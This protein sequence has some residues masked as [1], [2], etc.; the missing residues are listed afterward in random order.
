[1]INTR[2]LIAKPRSPPCK[3]NYTRL[4]LFIHLRYSD[5]SDLW[6][7][8]FHGEKLEV[9]WFNAV[10]LFF[11]TSE[12]ASLDEGEDTFL[13]HL[14]W[15]RSWDISELWITICGQCVSYPEEHQSLLGVRKLRPNP[16]KD[17]YKRLL[18]RNN[19]SYGARLL[20]WPRTVNTKVRDDGKI[21]FGKLSQNIIRAV[22]QHVGRSM[23]ETV[24]L[25]RW[26]PKE[27]SEIQH[28]WASIC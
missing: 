4:L 23:F 9:G 8:H 27:S 22:K 14:H 16:E 1:M 20:H 15:L 6:L 13:W 17:E 26:R 24:A 10:F 7:M 5:Q 11:S 12:T 21:L 2:L 25:P 3:T 19:Q 18:G 28:I